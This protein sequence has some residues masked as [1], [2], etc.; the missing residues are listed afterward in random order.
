MELA[1]Y[2]IGMSRS[3]LLVVGIFKKKSILQQWKQTVL[4]IGIVIGL[5]LMGGIVEAYMIE[6]LAG[7]NNPLL[8]VN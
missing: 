8:K 6:T 3:F 5:L 1:A 7:P 2:S 4:E